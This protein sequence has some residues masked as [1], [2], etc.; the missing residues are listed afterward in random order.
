V[1]I[2]NGEVRM[3]AILAGAA[4]VLLTAG[5]CS[6]DVTASRPRASA[7]ASSSSS[8]SAMRESNVVVSLR[9]WA[10]DAPRSA[11]A[12]SLT[13]T[14]TNDG[15][16]V[17]Q[18]VIIQTDL[19]PADLPTLK[20][21]SVK[22]ERIT[23]AGGIAYPPGIVWAFQI[24]DIAV[25]NTRTLPLDLDAGSYVLICNIVQTKPDGSVVAHYAEGMR[26]GFTVT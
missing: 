24:Q 7:A 14:I 8:A 9:E 1:L 6:H 5:A 12:G 25:G 17:H 21:G 23:P 2:R 20:D 26:T 13:F 22:D 19:A 15:H 16:Q 4:T 18:F 10:V 3:K 11:P